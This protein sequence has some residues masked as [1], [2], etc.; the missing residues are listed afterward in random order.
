M[1]YPKKN[2]LRP[3]YLINWIV[4]C[5]ARRRASKNLQPCIENLK[6]TQPRP[7]CGI[8]KRHTQSDAPMRFRN[9]I[10]CGCVG[11]FFVCLNSSIKARTLR[12]RP[13][14]F[15]TNNC[16]ACGNYC[17]ATVDETRWLC[18]LLHMLIDWEISF[19]K[20]KIGFLWLL[21]LV[22]KIISKI[23]T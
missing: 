22:N 3:L 18:I 9:K 8:T 21:L 16:W 7:W 5:R 15:I 2:P 23:T 17:F 19:R 1:N 14:L 20:R 13:W 10:L 12:P 4:G 6:I 11:L